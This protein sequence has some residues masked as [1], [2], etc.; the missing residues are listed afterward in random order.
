MSD[1]IQVLSVCEWKSNINPIPASASERT[2]GIF[3]FPPA[4]QYIHGADALT[5]FCLEM[6]VI[7]CPPLKTP[8]KAAGSFFSR[9]SGPSQIRVQACVNA[10]TRCGSLLKAHVRR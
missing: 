4:N 8:W 9:V 10:D 6:Q 5:Y 2:D 7:L 3:A 1:R